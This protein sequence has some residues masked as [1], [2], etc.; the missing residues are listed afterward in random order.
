MSSKIIYP[1]LIIIFSIL[2]IFAIINNRNNLILN[3][4]VEKFINLENFDNSS[5]C[6]MPRFPIPENGVDKVINYY[7]D[8]N[9][10]ILQSSAASNTEFTLDMIN[11]TWT[12]DLTT[13]DYNAN[14][15]N[16][17]TINA[18]GT[19]KANNYANTSK[20]FGTVAYNGET[21]NI[22]FLLNQNLTAIMANNPSRN[23]HIKFYNNFSTEGQKEINSP[24]YKPEEFNSVVSIYNN[25]TLL[26]K[27]ASYKV[28]GNKVG[29]E[30]YRI[31]LSG[32]V[33]IEKAAA[34]Y[35]YKSYNIIIGNYKF[36]SNYLTISGSVTDKTKIDT[37]NTKYKGNIRFFIQRV[38]YSPTNDNTELITSRSPDISLNVLNGDQIGQYITVCSFENDKNTN[39]LDAFFRPKATI[40]YFYKFKDITEKY[41]YADS[42][43]ITTSRDVLKINNN[44][45]TITA[46]NITYNQL[47]KVRKIITTNYIV[48][49][50]NRY[51]SDLKTV[52]N[53]PFSD[54]Y[55]L[56]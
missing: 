48:T 26:N 53:I 9:K 45:S 7:L 6:T 46:E 40:L 49:Y 54:L 42:P 55:N 43:N 50:V 3:K 37:I 39:G 31:L 15:S 47:D 41:D 36:P 2:I 25:D 1:I 12:S 20:N 38:F 13:V 5:S 18:S 52:T 11:G 8:E 29:D 16:L 30:L 4:N 28:Y 51:K 24:F 32:V 33:L 23:L 14:V 19:I 27:F 17:I 21:Y 35:D 44:A 56:L 34:V 22:N 10:N